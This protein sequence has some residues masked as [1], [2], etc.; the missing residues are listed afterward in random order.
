MGVADRG[1]EYLLSISLGGESAKRGRKERFVRGILSLIKASVRQSKIF[2]AKPA[3]NRILKEINYRVNFKY[4]Y[5][6]AVPTEK[7]CFVSF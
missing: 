7:P 2:I 6:Q 3:Q 5:N 1:T 4:F